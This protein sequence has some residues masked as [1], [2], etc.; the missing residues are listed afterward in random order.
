MFQ[1]LRA[2]SPGEDRASRIAHALRQ[3]GRMKRARLWMGDLLA[4]RLLRS[5][6]GARAYYA[7][8]S[9]AFAREQR[10]VAAGRKMYEDALR[11]HRRS[12][13]LLRR[14]THR[15]EKGLVTPGRKPV[16]ALNYIEETVAEF[17]AVAGQFD[18][19]EALT[20]EL[21]WARD[22]LRAYFEATDPE[23]PLLARL[24]SRFRQAEAGLSPSAG[25]SPSAPFVRAPEHPV[26]IDALQ[27]LT[28]QRRSVRTYLPDPV[29]RKVVDRAIAVAAQSPSACNR[30]PFGFRI[31]DDPAAARRVA[32]IPAG[33]RSYVDNIPAVVVLVGRLRAY[34]GER[35]RHAIYIDASLAAMAFILALEAQGVGSCAIN[36]AD[37][38]PRESR[39]ARL[40]GLAPDER[41]IM[42]ISYGWPDPGAPVPFSAKRSLDDLRSYDGLGG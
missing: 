20:P 41:V 31:F 10:A 35:D 26:G 5:P 13:Y 40:L 33:T 3:P 11:A 7:T 22:V 15:L 42:M 30:Q 34:A 16:F 25:G 28:I 21:R 32:A 14:N 9:D 6:A 18:R 19:T 4:A 27:A 36:W 8:L 29:P 38:E 12:S 1:R 24:A 37:E 17:E 23:D 2:A 39:I